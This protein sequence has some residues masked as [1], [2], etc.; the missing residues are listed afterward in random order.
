MKAASQKVVQ[1]T[2]QKAVIQKAFTLLELLVVLAI[3]AF[4]GMASFNMAGSGIR[5]QQAIES[6]TAG[7]EEAVRFWQWLERDMEQLVNR[8]VRDPLGEPQAALSLQGNRL[9][10]TKTGWQNPLL[11]NRSELQ[12]V[13]YEWQEERF[14]RRFWSVLDKDQQAKAVEQVFTGVSAVKVSL[15]G[16]QGWLTQWPASDIS[17]LR[18]EEEATAAMPT[19]I[20]IQLTLDSIGQVERMFVIPSFVYDTEKGAQ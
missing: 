12:R 2:V 10:F 8:P 1:K 6:Q 14:I 18:G 3:L 11:Y 4:V 7:V 17:N 5:V 9:V 16:P 19:G 13:E 15:L 20:K